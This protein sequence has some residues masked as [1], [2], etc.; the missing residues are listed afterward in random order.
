MGF[1]SLAMSMRTRIATA[2]VALTVLA[3]GFAHLDSAL[4]THAQSDKRA[5]FCPMHP[6][7]IESKGG[8]CPRC[9][10]D[11]VRGNPQE[12]VEYRLEVSTEP[13]AI[14]AGTG[15]TLRFRVVHPTSGDTV[16]DFEVVHAKRY[17]LFVVAQNFDFF[18]HVHP[19]QQQDGSWN[20]RI[21]LPRPGY[22]RLYSD[23]LGRGGVP[24][25]VVRT[26]ATTG[27]T[28]D[29]PSSKAQLVPDKVAVKTIGNTRV[30]LTFPSGPLTAGRYQRLAYHLDS[31][32]VP[33]RDLKPY[34]AAWG[35]TVVLSEDSLD[36]VHAHPIEYLAPD[37]VDPSGGPDITFDAL[38][39]RPG[40][41]RIW[42]QFLR[43]GEVSTVFFTVEAAAGQ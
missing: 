26:I 17:H 39:P 41:Y 20:L 15:V 4:L 29:L 18:D 40:R 5:W 33:V 30:S 36:Y 38:F 14:R 10:M 3:A 8:K 7:V 25:V 32:G 6:E 1:L 27:F 43:G 11:L 34:L 16:R 2:T 13:V 22:Y 42:T 23:F 9:S 35:H 24:Q 37:A 19:E 28:G 21:T 31:G 12:A